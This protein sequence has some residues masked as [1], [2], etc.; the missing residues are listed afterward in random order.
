MKVKFASSFALH[1]EGTY[2]RKR[3]NENFDILSGSRLQIGKIIFFRR[4]TPS[5]KLCQTANLVPPGMLK[6]GHCFALPLHYM[7]FLLGRAES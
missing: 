7:H 6:G 4:V 3:S 5:H 2:V 1:L